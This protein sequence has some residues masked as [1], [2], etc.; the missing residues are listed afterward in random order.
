MVLSLNG[1]GSHREDAEEVQTA[2]GQRMA[3]SG[4]EPERPWESIEKLLKVS[5]GLQGPAA[6]QPTGVA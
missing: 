2:V 4:R 1:L 3:E 5:H 6:E